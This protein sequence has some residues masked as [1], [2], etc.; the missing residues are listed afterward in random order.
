MS[1][2]R[3]VLLKQHTHSSPLLETDVPR[4]RYSSQCH[5]TQSTI[6]GA[7]STYSGGSS[8]ILPTTKMRYCLDARGFV[9]DNGLL[10]ANRSTK[11]RKR[12]RMEQSDRNFKCD[13]PLTKSC[14]TLPSRASERE[15]RTLQSRCRLM[16]RNFSDWPIYQT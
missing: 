7:V 6:S 5:A 10:F 9:S 4:G 11:P 15:A 3:V 2:K 14:P 16:E 12:S 8:G 1:Q 13:R